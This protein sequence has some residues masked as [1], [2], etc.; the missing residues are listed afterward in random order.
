[1]NIPDPI[2]AQAREL[3][4]QGRKAEAVKLLQTTLQV[5]PAKAYRAL[6]FLLDGGTATAAPVPEIRFLTPVL[7]IAMLVAMVCGLGFL[8]A[9]WRAY[10]NE[11]SFRREHVRIEGEVVDFT[12]A[13][14]RFRPIFEITHAGQKRQIPSTARIKRPESSQTEFRK[15]T[16]MGIWVAPLNPTEARP[17]TFGEAWVFTLVFGIL[18]LGFTFVPAALLLFDRRR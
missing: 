8:Y 1:M 9:G 3:A 13:G 7:R 15:G 5:S 11:V 16:R 6:E 10:E 18:G 12:A 14:N 2:R 17:D 4:A